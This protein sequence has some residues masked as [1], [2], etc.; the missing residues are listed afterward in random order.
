M[1]ANFINCTPHALTL[2]DGTV[3]PA[4]G[5]VAR[6]AASFTQ[7]DEN[8]VC[9]QVFGDVQGIPAPQE[10]T[11]YIVSALVLA[12][13]DRTDLVAPATGHPDCVRENGMIKSVPGFVCK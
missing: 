1:K 7:F 12:A 2:N 3:I 11:L 6:V 8:G 5:Q 9:K 10:G 4:S 13:S